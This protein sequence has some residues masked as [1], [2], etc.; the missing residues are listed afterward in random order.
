MSMQVVWDVMGGVMRMSFIM[1][2][3]IWGSC[4][5]PPVLACS[6]V[7]HI[8]AVDY[9]RLEFPSRFPDYCSRG[10]QTTPTAV[11]WWVAAHTSCHV[12]RNEG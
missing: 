1:S 4:L 2:C 3:S 12:V 5:L 11:I 9:Q 10:N 8:T 6:L 7:T